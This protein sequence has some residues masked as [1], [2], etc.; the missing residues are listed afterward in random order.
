MVDTLGVH[1]VGFEWML[2]QFTNVLQT[3]DHGMKKFLA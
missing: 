2:H 3:N 1:G